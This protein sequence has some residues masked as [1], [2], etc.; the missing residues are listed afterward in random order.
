MAT[1]TSLLAVL[2]ASVIDFVIRHVEANAR[3]A[4]R[5]LGELQV[6]YARLGELDWAARGGQGGG[7]PVLGP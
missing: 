7:A 3:A 1:S 4:T 6:A 2:L 5:M